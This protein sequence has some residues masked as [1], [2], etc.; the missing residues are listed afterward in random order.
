M[1]LVMAC[2]W[3]ATGVVDNDI[4]CVGCVRVGCDGVTNAVGIDYASNA[5]GVGVV[6]DDN[7]VV[8]C[9]LILIYVVLLMTHVVLVLVVVVTHNQCHNTQ[10]RH[11]T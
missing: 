8:N 1:R 9:W 3:C 4:G 7:C 10:P 11:H 5:C 2:V 6:V